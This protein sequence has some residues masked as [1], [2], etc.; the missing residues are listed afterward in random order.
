MQVLDQHISIFTRIL[1]N[2]NRSALLESTV[3]HLATSFVRDGFTGCVTLL[4][5]SPHSQCAV[6]FSANGIA[7]ILGLPE[8]MASTAKSWLTQVYNGTVLNRHRRGTT[9]RLKLDAS[10]ESTQSQ[11]N[12][13]IIRVFSWAISRAEKNMVKPISRERWNHHSTSIKV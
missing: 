12:I 11:F 6:V 5:P 8:Y 2:M 10:K 1:Q 4:S 9:S 7:E 13:I 3:L